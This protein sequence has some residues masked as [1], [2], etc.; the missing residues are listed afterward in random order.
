MRK[1]KVTPLLAALA[2]LAI[3]ACG[4][5]G[6][7]EGHDHGGAG[8]AEDGDHAEEIDTGPHGGRLL[9]DGD[10]TLEIVMDESGAES[11]FRLYAYN[12]DKPVPPA[13]L[14]ASVTLTRLGGQVDRISFQ[15]EGDY[16]Q[17]SGAVAEPHSFKVAVTA[18]RGGKRHEW[19]YPSHE[20]RTVIDAA[21]AREAGIKTEMAGPASI[22]TT[23]ELLGRTAFAPGAEANVKARFPGKILWLGK[24]VGE[25]VRAGE[26]L[27]RVESNESLQTYAVT[28]PIGG[29]VVERAANPGDVAGEEPLYKLGDPSR[30]VADLHVFDRD[31]GRVRPGQAVSVAPMHGGDAIASS[32]ASF[33]PVRE[34]ASQTVVARVPLQAG[35]VTW[36]PGMSVRGRVTVEQATVPLAVRAGALQRFRGFDVVFVRV[37]DIY[38]VRM[39]STGRRTSDWVEVLG[40]LNPGDEYVTANSFLIKADIEKSGAAHEH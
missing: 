15:P 31:M 9:R 10:F 30:L 8:H 37:G 34:A 18:S 28:A 36:M 32:I 20:S 40:G 25:T 5:G 16:L 26:V 14:A 22:D 4:E 24:G 3:A 7:T 17:G 13:E 29:F 35:D 27:A 39:L 6:K 33:V 19:R 11:R 23:V 2:V 1:I 12:K 38:E 21:A